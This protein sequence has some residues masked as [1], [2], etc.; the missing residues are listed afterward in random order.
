MY[1]YKKQ[2]YSTPI[3]NQLSV[4]VTCMTEK[5]TSQE[6]A[7]QGVV[8]NCV[9]LTKR[10][11]LPH[12]QWPLSIECLP[13]KTQQAAVVDG[14]RWSTSVVFFECRKYQSRFGTNS[15]RSPVDPCGLHTWAR[16]F[17]NTW[18]CYSSCYT[19]VDILHNG[20][21]FKYSF[22]MHLKTISINFT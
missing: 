12:Y 18:S 1:T 4:A 5:K 9:P 6:L 17:R 19:L 20:W 16:A 2:T 14:L 10:Y 3:S 21:D 8:S 15:C 13:N 7:Q 11:D 22:Y